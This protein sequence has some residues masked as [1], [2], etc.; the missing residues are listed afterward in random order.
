MSKLRHV[1]MVAELIGCP[2]FSDEAD[3]VKPG[4]AWHVDRM[5][6]EWAGYMHDTRGW[7]KTWEGLEERQRWACTLL[8]ALNRGAAARETAME[9][10]LESEL[11]R[12]LAEE[13]V[14]T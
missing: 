8:V 2:P 12:L 13:W 9:R 7:S 6:G 1:N 5:L 14:V 3:V 11:G 4:M 10:L